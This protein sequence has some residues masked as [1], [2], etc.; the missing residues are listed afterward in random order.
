MGRLFDFSFA[1]IGLIF[2]LPFIAII[3]I[4]I[5]ITSSG[6]VLFSQYRV[7]LNEKI[8]KTYKFRTMVKGADRIGTSV[9][10]ENDGRITAIGKFLRKTKLDELPQIF[11]VLIGDMSFVGPRPDVSEIVNNYTGGMKRIFKVKPGITSLATLH[12]KDEEKILS[13]VSEPDTFY[14][15]VLVPLK[16]KIAMEHVDRNSFFF[17]LKIFLQ[18]LWMLSFLGKI[19][20]IKEHPL[21]VDLKKKWGQVQSE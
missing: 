10:T 13:K 14:E 19:M 21:V 3:A 16:V 2:C 5:K 15:K 11:N 20:P 18:T 9:T 8:F 6:P 7:G 17:N 12:L 4:F 1:L